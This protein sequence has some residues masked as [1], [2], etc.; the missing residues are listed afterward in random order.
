MAKHRAG[1]RRIISISIPEDLAK[2]LDRRVGKG[3]NQGRSAT[4]AKMIQNGLETEQ[5]APV[6]ERASQQR[7]ASGASG[8]I[9]IEKDTMGEL[10]VPAD[11]YFGA[12]T[13]RSLIN[14]DIGTDTMPSS[15]IRAFGILK[16]AAAET[17]VKLG[18][19]DPQIGALI[20]SACDEVISG[21]M[22]EHFPLRVWQT[23]SGT[24]TNM[25]SNEVIA[26]RA[27]E[28]AGGE[29]GSKS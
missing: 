11:R 25:N 21:S 2:K 5:I 3:R 8:E 24:Q 12:Q 9:R 10:E 20:T 4:I 7:T 15:V 26:N 23:G 27:I 17:N 6:Q 22:D 14:F 29:L 1:D 19:L 28:M 18:Q 16:Q 13:A